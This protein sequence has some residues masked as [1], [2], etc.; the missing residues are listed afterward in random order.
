[1]E[2][3]SSAESCPFTKKVFVVVKNGLKELDNFYRNLKVY[4]NVNKIM[5]NMQVE[6]FTNVIRIY[7]QLIKVLELML[8]MS[9]SDRTTSMPKSVLRFLGR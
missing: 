8:R 1:M 5:N 4:F 9:K 3:C 6:E 7:S 2:L